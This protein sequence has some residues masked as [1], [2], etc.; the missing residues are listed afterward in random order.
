MRHAVPNQEAER[1]LDCCDVVA[2]HELCPETDGI[3]A[4]CEEEIQE[5][6]SSCV[7]TAVQGELLMKVMRGE[8]RKSTAQQLLYES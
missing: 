5:K 6:V 4:E 2:R 1:I 3:I 8:M 7:M